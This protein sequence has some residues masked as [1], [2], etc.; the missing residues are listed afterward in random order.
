VQDPHEDDEAFFDA[1]E[2]DDPS[3]VFD[4][5]PAPDKLVRAQTEGY[6]SAAAPPP[7]GV[8]VRAKTDTAVR[9][10]RRCRLLKCA[11][12]AI[13]RL[14]S[15]NTLHIEPLP[16]TMS[17]WH[18]PLRRR[19]ARKPAEKKIAPDMEP[20]QED[21]DAEAQAE[22]ELDAGVEG[23]GPAR[24]DPQRPNS[25]TTRHA[26][27][28]DGRKEAEDPKASSKKGNPQGRK[29]DGY[30]EDYRDDEAPLMPGDPN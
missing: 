19:A 1:I 11:D 13:S 6:P 24:R 7:P 14:R 8:L 3:S 15:E 10:A 22:A 28:R 16:E 27:T 23:L 21:N 12:E 18:Q 9:S 4:F 17:T 26:Q 25:K 30:S 20:V 2:R 5:V 29:S